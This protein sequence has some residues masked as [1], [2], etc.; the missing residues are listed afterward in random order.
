MLLNPRSTTFSA[1][2]FS[3][4]KGRNPS[5]Q[6]VGIISSNFISINKDALT[7]LLVYD[8]NILKD[9][10]NTFVLNSIIEYI[11]ST[12]C[13][14]NPLISFDLV[15]INTHLSWQLIFWVYVIVLIFCVFWDFQFIYSTLS[16]NFSFLSYKVNSPGFVLNVSIWCIC[17]Y[18]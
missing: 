16:N 10:T 2:R 14:Y 8:D 1:A 5:P 17:L 15:N 12:K 6:N 3:S 18:V 4:M 9:S 13:C 11:T 7:H